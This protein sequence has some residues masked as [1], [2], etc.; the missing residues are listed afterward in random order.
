MLCPHCGTA[1]TA[2][3]FYCTNCG[4]G[5]S[6]SVPLAGVGPA[7][8]NFASPNWPQSLLGRTLENRYRLEEIIGVG[9]MGTV[10]RAQRLLIG[11]AAAIKVLHPTLLQD[12]EAAPRFHREAQTAA[13]LKHPNAIAIYDF[14][15]TGGLYF[16]VMEFF[17][18]RSLGALIK[19]QPAGL[20]LPLAITITVQVCAALEEAHRQGIVHRDIK[21]DNILVQE[22]AAGLQVKVLDFGIAKLRDQ[23]SN[24]TRTGSVMG[25]PQYMS[26]EQCLGEE[27]DGCSDI[28]SLAIALYEM[29]TGRVPFHAPSLAAVIGQQVHKAP[30]PLR[31]HNP[32]VPPAL[33]TA[34]LRALAKNPAERPATAGHFAQELRTATTGSHSPSQISH[35][36]WQAQPAN[37]SEAAPTVNLAAVKRGPAVV[38]N[39]AGKAKK[40]CGRYWA[41]WRPV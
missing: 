22:S 19:E 32:A 40:V 13:R 12:A 11:D 2:E 4:G 10:F 31:T 33:E 14:A 6:G 25:T 9:G 16:I 7:T 37:S 29:L 20:P 26:P 15:A 5:L 17:A 18:G 1:N 28:Y 30:P 38:N 35:K 36:Q 23:T 34:V 41:A 21:P 27:L 39:S 8:W 3:N 24:L